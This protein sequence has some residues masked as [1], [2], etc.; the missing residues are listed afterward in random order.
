MQTGY[1][2]CGSVNAV[3]AGLKK[4]VEV[5]GNRRIVFNN[6]DVLEMISLESNNVTMT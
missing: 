6:K 2:I 1:T 3:P 4:V 5:G